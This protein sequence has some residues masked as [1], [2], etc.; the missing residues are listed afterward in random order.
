MSRTTTF[1]EFKPATKAKWERI[2][3]KCSALAHYDSEGDADRIWLKDEIIDHIRQVI[4][5]DGDVLDVRREQMYLER[6]RMA[7]VFSGPEIST[8]DLVP[9]QNNG[10]GY[11][12]IR[13]GQIPAGFLSHILAVAGGMP[14]L[15]FDYFI[16]MAQD[17]SL[18]ELIGAIGSIRSMTLLLLAEL[19]V[20]VHRSDE[21]T[22]KELEDYLNC[23]AEFKNEIQ[24]R[25]TRA[26]VDGFNAM[27]GGLLLKA[28][29]A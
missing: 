13:D 4:F 26:E 19:Y 14:R 6:M 25:I 3:R 15:A 2:A 28:P 16:L 24:G 9:N 27:A 7:S 10:F 12:W 23:I 17:Y 22:N 5:D 8:L 18:E 29:D 21:F 1:Y 20:R 11:K